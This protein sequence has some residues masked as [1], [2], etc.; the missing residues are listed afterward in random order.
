M[1]YAAARRSAAAAADIGTPQVLYT[2]SNSAASSP[3]LPSQQHSISTELQR[4]LPSALLTSEH[5]NH[6]A[7]KPGLSTTMPEVVHAKQPPKPGFAFSEATPTAENHDPSGA[8]AALQ[9]IL[10]LPDSISGER[11]AR[12][13]Q[14]LQCR[15]QRSCLDFSGFHFLT[16]ILIIPGGQ[17][18][19]GYVTVPVACT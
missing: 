7:Y 3:A 10:T 19:L 11:P 15:L 6:Q 18:C 14:L 17:A 12:H 13:T 5:Q 4:L 16:Y 9:H 2:G 8:W 1:R